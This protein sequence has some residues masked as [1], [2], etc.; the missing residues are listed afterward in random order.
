MAAL[1]ASLPPDE[2]NP[3]EFR[4]YE[5]FGPEV[6]RGIEGWAPRGPC[7]LTEYARLPIRGGVEPTVGR[8]MG[9]KIC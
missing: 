4:L 5:S 6:P 9:V 2:L 3:V 1:A 7:T 8:I